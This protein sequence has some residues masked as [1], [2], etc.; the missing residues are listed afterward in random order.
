M[1]TYN[2]KGNRYQID[3]TQG[4]KFKCECNGMNIERDTVSAVEAEIRRQID[5]EKNVAQVAVLM[6]GESRW[7]R[8]DYQTYREGKS[9]PINVGSVSHPEY[10]VTWKDKHQRTER[11]KMEDKAVFV[12]N[13]KNRS[14]MNGVTKLSHEISILE[15][16]QKELIEGLE[17]LKEAKNG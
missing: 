7:G 11:A 8:Y 4:E 14:L 17:T 5:A 16:K 12:D 1:K 15:A 10:W 13:P 3:L 6:F 9:R 2:Y